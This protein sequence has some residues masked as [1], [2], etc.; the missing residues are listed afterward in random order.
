MIDMAPWTGV[1]RKTLHSGVVVGAVVG[2]VAAVSLLVLGVMLVVRRRSR[3]RSTALLGEPLN[4]FV[5][6]SDSRGD[7]PSPVFASQ[8]ESS[9][10]NASRD[11]TAS[12]RKHGPQRAS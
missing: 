12:L 10:W 6:Y 3:K 2:S 11:E 7:E 8:V 5:D 9:V 4:F 1:D